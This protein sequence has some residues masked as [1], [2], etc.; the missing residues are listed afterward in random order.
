MLFRSA[1]REKLIRDMQRV[2]KPG[3]WIYITTP[4]PLRVR[5]LHGKRLFGNQWH[6]DGEA[7]ASSSTRLRRYF[8]GWELRYPESAVR[9]KLGDR[10]RPLALLP[11]ALVSLIDPWQRLLLRKPQV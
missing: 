8:R 11:S 9:E 6:R 10:F 2:S 4:N 3:G 5:E 1:N 7:W